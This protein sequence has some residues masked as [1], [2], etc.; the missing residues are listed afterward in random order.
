MSFVL[1]NLLQSALGHAPK[2]VPMEVAVELAS[3]ADCNEVRIM[4]N[5]NRANPEFSR[6]VR[7][8]LWAFGGELHHTRDRNSGTATTSVRLPRVRS[9]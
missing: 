8:A 1:V 2:G 5:Q 7:C 6:A 9:A 4:T 3:G